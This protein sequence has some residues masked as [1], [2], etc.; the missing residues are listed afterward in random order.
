[1]S[2][3]ISF[4]ELKAR[5]ETARDHACAANDIVQ[6]HNMCCAH[7]FDIMRGALGHVAACDMALLLAQ[8]LAHPRGTYA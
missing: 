4:T 8:L 7:H 6:L 1:M 5:T 3:R 2:A